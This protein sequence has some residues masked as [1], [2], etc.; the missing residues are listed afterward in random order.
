MASLLHALH[1]RQPLP[2]WDPKAAAA[3]V[4][5]AKKTPFDELVA[6]IESARSIAAGLVGDFTEADELHAQ[7]DEVLEFARKHCWPVEISAEDAHFTRNEEFYMEQAR[8]C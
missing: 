6:H 5:S 7:L 8:G 1:E 4:A 3:L 2:V